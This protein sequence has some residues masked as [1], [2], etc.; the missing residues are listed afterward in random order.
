M[1]QLSDHLI[2]RSAFI[3]VTLPSAASVG[4]P[5]DSTWDSV[6]GF[7]FSP[8]MPNK[9]DSCDHP[10]RCHDTATSP[11]A[12]ASCGKVAGRK[13]NILDYIA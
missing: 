10:H 9:N 7:L 12:H 1:A 13:A 5:L 2:K 4:S 3:I 8:V 11:V 6:W